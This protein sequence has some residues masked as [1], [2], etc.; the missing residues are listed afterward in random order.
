MK[1]NTKNQGDPSNRV[2][3]GNN[4][5]NNTNTRKRK[6]ST[7]AK[8]TK[9]VLIAICVISL[10]TTG[11]IMLFNT[12][13]LS[14]PE[15]GEIEETIKTPEAKK[16][17]QMNILVVG[18]DHIKAQE[19][20]RAGTLTDVVMLVNYDIEN[21]K[22]NI[23]QIPRDTYI[24][25]DY[26]TGKINAIYGAKTDGGVTGLAN[27][28]N[29]MLKIPIDYYVTLDLDGLVSLVDSIGGVTMD[30]PVSFWGGDNIRIKKGLQTINGKQAEAIVRERHSYPNADLGRIQTQRLFM[31]A[32]MQQM[33]SLGKTQIIKL[34]PTMINQVKTD[35]TLSQ[36]ISMYGD[37]MEGAKDN[38]VFHDMPVES[39]SK[40]GL[41]LLAIKPEETAT[42]LNEFFRPFSDAIPA[43][44]LELSN[45]G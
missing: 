43:E 15:Q 40:N 37:V 32:A 25:D 8:V 29:Q 36:L 38:I 39:A 20:K 22:I 30:V 10:V 6:S 45:L 1:K 4:P 19:G 33:F 35:F 23:V 24:G 11:V 44:N 12:P 3:R 17:K 13:V 42:L 9:A 41:S 18:V 7:K 27:K 31:Q 14:E 2:V 21:E 34:A 26:P 16:K 28:I 5:K